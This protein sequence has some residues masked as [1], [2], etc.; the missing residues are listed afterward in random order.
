MGTFQIQEVLLTAEALAIATDEAKISSSPRPYT[1]TFR[2]GTGAGARLAQDISQHA[3]PL[4]LID[5][6]V[7]LLYLKDQPQIANVPRFELDVNEGIKNIHSVLE[8]VDF[9]ER[10]NTSR[11]SMLFAVGGGIV[12]DLAA[13]ASYM[14]KRGIPWTFVPTTL[15]AQGDSSV[16]GKTALNHKDTKN[17]LALFSAPRRIIT[18]TGF[19]STLPDQDWYSGAGEI[20]RLCI[21]GGEQ[22]L[23]ILEQLAPALL[24]HDLEH[25]TDL[26]RV[27]LIVKKA[28]VEFDEFELDIRRSMNYGHSFGHALESLANYRIPHGVGVTIGILVENEISFRRGALS[29]GE[30]DRLLRLGNLLVPATSWSIFQELSLDGILDLLK[31]DKKTEGAV[32]KLATLKRIGHITFMDLHMDP[33]GEEEVKAAATSVV[34]EIDALRNA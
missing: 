5:R 7:Y 29:Q 12:Q 14:Y 28:V 1:M 31:R 16:G 26:I 21:T 34:Q 9:M 3:R 13:F 24:Q 33:H 17:L 18:D 20:F 10:N 6:S 22:S 27:A 11:T 15:L 25:T 30:R 2:S 4:L 19:L 32:L 23:Q 8:I